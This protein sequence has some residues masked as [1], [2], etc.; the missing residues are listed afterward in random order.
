MKPLYEATTAEN[1]RKQKNGKERAGRDIKTSK[2]PIEWNDEMRKAFLEAKTALAKATIL[3]HPRTGAENRAERGRVRRS[4]RCCTATAAKRR[5]RLGAIGILQQKV[6]PGR[7]EIQRIRPRIAGSLPGS[8]PFPALSRRPGFPDIYGPSASHVC[9]GKSGR[10]M[11]TQAGQ[12]PGLPFR[13]IRR[14]SDM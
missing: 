13:S 2:K 9:D 3:R 8:S 1:C 10:T 12:A 11:V 7:K 4:C 5:W 14:T 6:E